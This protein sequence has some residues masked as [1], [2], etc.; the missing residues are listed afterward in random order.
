MQLSLQLS[1]DW[2]ERVAAS[3]EAYGAMVRGMVVQLV[4][5]PVKGP[6]TNFTA[7]LPWSRIDT[8]AAFTSSMSAVC[9]YRGIEAIRA[10]PDV[11]VG[12]IASSWG[13]TAINVW[14]S[15]SALAECDAG[16]AAKPPATHRAMATL[17]DPGLESSLLG[18]VPTTDSVL[19]YNMITPLLTTPVSSFI[20]YQGESK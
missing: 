19:Y 16:G 17:A 11:P 4:D 15:P 7:M 2:S 5:T 20:W 10:R 6:Q 12:L 18:D 1:D 13:G 14:M 3:A 8:S 9:F